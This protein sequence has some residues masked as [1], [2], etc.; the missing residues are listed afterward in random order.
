MRS[1]PEMGDGLPEL[2]LP[3]LMP[4][5]SL[6]ALV[7]K[8]GLQELHFLQKPTGGS[9]CPHGRSCGTCGLNLTRLFSYGFFPFLLLCPCPS[10][11][12]CALISRR[13]SW[14]FQ[15][16]K[17]EFLNIMDYGRKQEVGGRG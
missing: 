17:E 12:P 13:Y 4:G 9:K 11:A 15:P 8:L 5:S 7:R 10:P 16:G 1:R 3:G 2:S 14:T 6:L